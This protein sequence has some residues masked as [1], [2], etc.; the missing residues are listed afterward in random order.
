MTLNP[1]PSFPHARHFVLK[2]HR[3]ANP[4]LCIGRLENL[5]GGQ[6]VDFADGAALLACLADILSDSTDPAV[7]G[8][9]NAKVQP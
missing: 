5:A 4:S 1:E 6:C 2:L 8:S 9:A 7:T 3:R